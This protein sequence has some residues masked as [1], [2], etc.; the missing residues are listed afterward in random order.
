MSDD[1]HRGRSAELRLRVE[2]R[3]DGPGTITVEYDAAGE[4]GAY[5][6]GPVIELEGTGEWRTAELR[7][8]AAWLD[9]RQNRGSDL[10]LAGPFDYLVGRVTLLR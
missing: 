7:L 1:F 8:P 10:R 3:D 9:N 6:A 5:H 4:Q 2:Y